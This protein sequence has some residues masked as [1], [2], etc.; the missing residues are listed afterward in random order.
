MYVTD[1]LDGWRKLDE[2]GLIQEDFSSG[3]ADSDDLG[4]LQAQRFA[5][6]AGVAN[7]QQTLDHVVDVQLSDFVLAGDTAARR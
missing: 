1:N 7:I 3:L 4:I 5:N 6:L 2:S